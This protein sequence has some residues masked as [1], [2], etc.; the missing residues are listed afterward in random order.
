MPIAYCVR[1]DPVNARAVSECIAPLTKLIGTTFGA[2]HNV[3]GQNTDKT[4][5]FEFWNIQ[6]DISAIPFGVANVTR[7][8]IVLTADATDSTVFGSSISRFKDGTAPNVNS[9]TESIHRQFKWLARARDTVSA[10]L[11]LTSSTEVF[12]LSL[13]E[14]ARGATAPGQVLILGSAGNGFLGSVSMWLAKVVGGSYPGTCVAKVYEVSGSSGFYTKGSLLATS[15][16]RNTV[17]IKDIS[18]SGFEFVFTFPSPEIAVTSGQIMLAEVSFDPEPTGLNGVLVI[19]DSDFNL[20][21]DNAL[22]FGPSMQAFD[23]AVYMNGTEQFTAN[24]DR[25]ATGESFIF[26]SF[27]SGVQYEL[28]DADYSPD[29]ELTNFTQWVQ[30]GLD[31]R[32]ASNHLSFSIIPDTFVGDPPASGEERRWR[33]ADHATPQTV[34]GESFFGTVLVVEYTIRGPVRSFPPRARPAVAHGEVVARPA[35]SSPAVPRAR[36]AVRTPEEA[37][38]RPAINRGEARARPT[39]RRP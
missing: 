10:E 37:R 2:D 26:P 21:P 5:V 35:V 19:G 27:T 12:Q 18:G 7:A 22:V 32:G 28:G 23:E 30:D 36:A 8:K 17:D 15:D 34:D 9:V 11:A 16:S 1:S 31:G 25:Y 20:Q 3:A 39:V 29:V 4:P 33:S 38:A 13:S 24:G 14:S 6:Y